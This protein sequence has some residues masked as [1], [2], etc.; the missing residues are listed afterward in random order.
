MQL[1]QFNAESYLSESLEHM[2]T[3]MSDCNLDLDSEKVKAEETH[4]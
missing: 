1:D 3:I 2:K 4:R